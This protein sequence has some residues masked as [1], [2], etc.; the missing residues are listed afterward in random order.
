MHGLQ[1]LPCVNA[2]AV[3]RDGGGHL[4]EFLLVVITKTKHG[5]RLRATGSISYTH[6]HELFLNKLNDLGFDAGKFGLHSLWSGGA[7]AA[8]NAGVADRLFKRHRRWYSE[9]WIC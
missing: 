2:G 9:R 7:S 3:L 8:A 1:N 5:E 6:M 4:T